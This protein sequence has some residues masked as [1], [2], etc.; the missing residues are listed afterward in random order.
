[1]Q[2]SSQELI[3][4]KE[5]SIFNRSNSNF[6][7]YRKSV[8][9]SRQNSNNHTDSNLEITKKVINFKGLHLAPQ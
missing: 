2:N 3:Q 1:M 4:Q 8:E 7:I 9:R 5:P 6:R